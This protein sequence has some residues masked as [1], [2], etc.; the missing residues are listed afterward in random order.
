MTQIAHNTPAPAR[1]RGWSRFALSIVLLILALTPLTSAHSRTAA[2]V[3]V[4]PKRGGTL[5]FVQEQVSTLD[6][7]PLGDVYSA[8]VAAQIHRG[9]LFYGT[10]LTPMPDL[11]ESWTISR[12]G[13]DYVFRLRQGA[14]FH[15]GR[16]VTMKDVIFTFERT[17]APGGDPGLA[18]PFLSVIDGAEEFAAG[19]ATRIKGITALSDRN[20]RIHLKRPDAHFLWALAM[21][22]A[23]VVPKAEFLAMGEAEFA[24]H[25]IGCG[26]FRLLSST[27]KALTLVA[28]RNYYR[29]AAWLDTLVFVTA[30]ASDHAATVK[31][32]LSNQYDIAEVPGLHREKVARSSTVRLVSRRELALSF[33]GLNVR[34]EPFTDPKVRQALA[35][36]VDREAILRLNPSGQV[37]ATGVL[38]PGMSCYSPDDKT[39]PFDI[40]KARQKLAEAGHPGGKGLKPIPYYTSPGSARNHAVDSMLVA[41][42][43]LA[44]LPVT[45]VTITWVELQRRIDAFDA[46]LFSLSWVADI[47]DPDS[48]VGSLFESTSP[49]NYSRYRNAEVDSLI[50]RGRTTVDPRARQ[51]IYDRVERLVVNDAPVVPLYTT[52][53]AYGVRRG[54]Y[55]L[56]LTPMGISCV[57]LANVWIGE[58]EDDQARLD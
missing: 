29:R 14:R 9:L 55:G 41:N 30:T 38:P 58:L 28:W 44:G 52:T 19:K 48:F 23:A 15:N 42:W 10:N 24:R 12:D 34:L 26:P 20:L 54:V 6:P 8:T 33:L 18:G 53:S 2:L 5:R 47:P 25:P 35:L 4:Q 16:D 37:V 39:F 51:T 46:P 32:L 21:T 43:R 22:P 27:D 7:L 49:S 36:G 13:L 50:A 17:F 45:P 40:A 56:E 1:A 57:D 11:A 31:G 3:T